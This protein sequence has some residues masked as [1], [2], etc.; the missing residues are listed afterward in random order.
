MFLGLVVLTKNPKAKTNLSFFLFVCATSA[1]T[2]FNYLTDNVSNLEASLW[3]ARFANVFGLLGV[4]S[5]WQFV[6]FF[7]HHSKGR[8][9]GGRFLVAIPF[10]LLSL[11]SLGIKEVTSITESASQVLGPAY[12]IIVIGFLIGFAGAIIDLARGLGAAKDPYSKSSIKLVLVGTAVTFLLAAATNIF[13]P[14]VASSWGFSRFGPLFTLCLVLCISIAIIKHRLFDIRPIIARSLAYLFS[15]ACIGVIYVAIFIGVASHVFNDST[16]DLTQQV[17]YLSLVVATAL[18]FQ[19]IKRRF[20]RLTNSLFYRDSYD[21]QA[22]LDELN[23]IL[24][25]NIDINDLLTRTATVISRNLKAEYCLFAIKQDGKNASL[26]VFGTKTSKAIAE[27]A[28]HLQ[29]LLSKISQNVTFRLDLTD[30]QHELSRVLSEASVGIVARLV[31]HSEVVGYILI[32]EK[33]SGNPYSSQDAK[34]VNIISDEMSIASQNSLRFE[35]I[36]KFN[37][38][39]QE[40]IDEATRELRK[41][42]AKL[43]ALD[44][45]KDEFISMASHQLRTPLTSAKGYISMVLEG[46]TGRISEAQKAMLQQAFDSSQRMVYLIADLLNVSRLKTGKFIIENVATNLAD[47]IEAEIQQIQES[48][49]ARG[50]EIIYDKPAHFPTV[51]LDET[52]IRQVIMNFLDNAMYYTPKGGTIT[53]TLAESDKAIEFGVHDTGVGVSPEDQKH[54][55]T[56]F[57]RAQNARKMRPDGTGLGLYMAKKVVVSQ[58]GAII[59][60]SKV[61]E[62]ST[63]GFSFPL[64]KLGKV[65]SKES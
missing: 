35:E 29:P 5:F 58:G 61:G 24:V 53:V 27:E 2:I 59:F 49:Q 3:C 52:K 28:E 1:W 30:R 57:Y 11:T 47:V 20:D 12:P 42:N 39:L 9:L 38:T 40:K 41:T 13:L 25:S 14:L 16:S 60:R 23:S 50:L 31:A 32:G 21:P 8:L 65:P 34:I 45:A 6:S 48:A 56:K 17:F 33:K 51:L 64:D 15:L 63:F 22:F 43:K 44:E 62:G 46:D 4:Y 37:I 18:I 26:R 54:L 55:F 36:S 10:V 19:P 7:I